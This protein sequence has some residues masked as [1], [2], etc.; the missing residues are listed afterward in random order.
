MWGVGL[1]LPRGG[2][3]SLPAS[4]RAGPVQVQAPLR[5]RRRGPVACR[6][7]PQGGDRR[8]PERALPDGM[9]TFWCFPQ[10]PL[11]RIGKRVSRRYGDENGTSGPPP[12]RGPGDSPEARSPTVRRRRANGAGDQ[13]PGTKAPRRYGESGADARGRR[14]SGK[15]MNPDGMGAFFVF[16]M[17]L[18]KAFE[19]QARTK[20]G[21]NHRENDT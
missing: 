15:T 20:R 10:K 8:P 19:K 18:E 21:E 5:H 7:A 9:A 1:R 2:A 16:Q 12:Q 3:C 17:Y 11:R 6:R 4:P 14:T 13:R